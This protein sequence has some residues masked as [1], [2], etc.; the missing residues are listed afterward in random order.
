MF[1]RHYEYY[2]KLIEAG[3]NDFSISL[4]A[5]CASTGDMMAGNI[6]GSWQT[7]VDNIKKLSKLTYVTV[8]VVL[9]EDNIDD[10]NEIIKYAAY[11]LN[12]SDIRV[13][14][15]AQ[16]ND[17]FKQK[18]K[19]LTVPEDILVKNP[20]LKYRL[21]HFKDGR[22]VRGIQSTDSHKCPLVLDDMAVLNGK[23]FP[24]I[25]YLREGGKAIGDVSETMRT[26]RQAW[27]D[28]TDTHKE[29]ICQKNCLDVCIDYN[30]RVEHFQ[31]K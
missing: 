2:L 12:V 5:C 23:H 28:K 7:V 21:K 9:T 14:S 22:N 6:K 20:I 15:A 10:F 30:N 16:W 25:I 13:I 1:P 17:D 26:E 19:T 11:D 18:V 3:V 29:P 8:G 4:D 27:Y 24:C 31:G